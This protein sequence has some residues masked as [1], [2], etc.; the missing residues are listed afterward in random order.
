MNYTITINS[1]ESEQAFNFFLSEQTRFSIQF[2]EMALINS[3]ECELFMF[4]VVASV[5]DA[6]DS[7]ASVIMDTVPLCKNPVMLNLL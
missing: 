4:Y 7:I 2:L 6:E 1:S 5:A 3:V